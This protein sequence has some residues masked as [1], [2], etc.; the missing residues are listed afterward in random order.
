MDEK[1]LND[2][3]EYLRT[4]LDRSRMLAD[5]APDVQKLIELLVWE[6]RTLERRPTE[7]SNISTFDVDRH[8]DSLYARIKSSLPMIPDIDPRAITHVSSATLSSASAVV[9]YV[10]SVARLETPAAVEYASGALAEYR[11]LQESN[12][13]PARV[14]SLLEQILPTVGKSLIARTRHISGTGREMVP[15]QRLRWKCEL[16]LIA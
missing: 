3:H 12:Q 15:R 11:Q 9:A 4:W 14:R 16:F 1:K 10:S 2:A 5:A 7:A 13:Q 8:A 6:K